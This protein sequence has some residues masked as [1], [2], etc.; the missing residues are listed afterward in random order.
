MK[1]RNSKDIFAETLLELSDQM[2]IDRITVTLLVKESGLSAKTFYN[3]FSSIY[4]LMS[5]IEE[6]QARKFHEKLMTGEYSFSNYMEDC[7]HQYATIKRFIRNASDNT[8]GPEAFEKLHAETSYK[9]TLE[10]LLKQNRLETVP[11]EI[12]FALRMYIYGMVKV[13]HDF[14]FGDCKMTEAEFMK[15]CLEN[16]PERLRPYLI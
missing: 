2:P 5:Y 11:E 8:S 12:D 15:N 10:F 4:A 6:D 13:F 3:H 1:K 7:L 16:M 9:L 14:F